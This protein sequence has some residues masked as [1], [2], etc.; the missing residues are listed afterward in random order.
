MS[1]VYL[2]V[3]SPKTGT[4]YLQ[5]VLGRNRT[6]LA[7][8]GLL[9]P[10]AAEGSHFGAAIDLLDHRWGGALSKARG[11]WDLVAQAAAKAPDRAVISHEVL[12]AATPKQVARARQSLGDAEV[13]LIVTARDLARQIPAEWQETVKHRGRKTFARF[14]REIRKAPRTGSDL[15]FWRV[16]GL[17]DVL[18]RWG[19]G[20]RPSHVHVVTVPHSGADPDLLWRRFASVL[21]VDPAL[22]LQSGERTNQS[23]GIAETALIRRLNAQLKGRRIQQPVYANVVRDLLVHQ[24]LAELDLSARAVVAPADRP[25][26]E[27]ITEEWI[28]WLAAS[29]VSVV[30]NVEELRPRWPEGDW[31]DPDQPDPEAVV[32]AAVA[33]LAELVTERS[34][35]YRRTSSRTRRLSSVWRRLRG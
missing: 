5:D 13:H 26:V 20:L 1:R 30:G 15:W 35:D 6:T 21:G 31:V 8:H 22:Q 32:E 14:M 12:A 16:Q 27:E 17:P 10:D 33:A 4:S 25:M 2:H 7:S 3:G 18:T 28:E 24:T 23:M 9:Y 34:A 11:Q 29:G 19:H